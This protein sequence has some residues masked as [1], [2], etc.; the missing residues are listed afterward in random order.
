MQSREDE[1]I[2]LW[3]RLAIWE[4]SFAV[5]SKANA[6]HMATC[7]TVRS[8]RYPD[9][10]FPIGDLRHTAGSIGIGTRS[11]AASLRAAIV[12]G[13]SPAH[14]MTLARYGQGSLSTLQKFG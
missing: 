14:R 4:S 10:Q 8:V 1:E 9:A 5:R 12:D 7:P 2:W 6:S 11:I 13:L 3:I